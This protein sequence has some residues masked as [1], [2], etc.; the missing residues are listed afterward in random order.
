MVTM[1]PALSL[2]LY[3][4]HIYC[5]AALAK[6]DLRVEARVQQLP[7]LWQGEASG[8]FSVPFPWIQTLSCSEC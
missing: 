7:S 2:A 4:S 3:N 8:C 1:T 6:P 5:V